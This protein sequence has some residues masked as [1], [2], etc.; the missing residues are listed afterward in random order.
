MVA[1]RWIASRRI[2]TSWLRLGSGLDSASPCSTRIGI[3]GEVSHNQPREL[4]RYP[5]RTLH[6]KEAGLRLRVSYSA[7]VWIT[8]AYWSNYM[9]S[10]VV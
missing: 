10:V 9:R 3:P 6:D 4:I 2:D 5:L 8:S 7:G 1:T